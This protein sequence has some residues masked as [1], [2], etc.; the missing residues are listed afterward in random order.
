M[1]RKEQLKTWN[2]GKLQSTEEYK[3][4]CDTYLNMYLMNEEV[5]YIL[6]KSFE[7]SETPFS[8]DD[9]E[10]FYF[11][12]DL[13]KDEIIEQFKSM[14]KEEKEEFTE[15]LKDNFI[16]GLDS[17]EE[18]I[19]S[20]NEEETKKL[21]EEELNLN[22]RVEDY[23]RQTE[24][25]QWF[26]VCDDRILEQLEKRDEVILNNKF[27]GRQCYGQ[28]ITMDGVIIE[29]FK[30]WYLELYGLPFDLNKEVE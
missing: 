3:N 25:M 14:N 21:I 17:E 7:D 20:L 30:E 23:E 5:E 22:L 6:K 28:S 10:H 27:W 26:L 29:I 15:Y 18:L 1:N 13:A 8:Y 4:F 9:F 11:D 16:I 24:V 12:D 19:R 2:F